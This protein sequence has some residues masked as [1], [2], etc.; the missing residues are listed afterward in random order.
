[1]TFACCMHIL[2]QTLPSQPLLPFSRTSNNIYIV[3]HTYIYIHIP[4]ACFPVS[5]FAS[6]QLVPS[7]L[8]GKGFLAT[9][10]LLICWLCSSQSGI[11]VFYLDASCSLPRPEVVR[12]MTLSFEKQLAASVA[13]AFGLVLSGVVTVLKMTW[14]INGQTTPAWFPTRRLWTCP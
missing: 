11:L 13:M 14:G 8:L 5:G 9:W 12:A 1:M 10:K 4:F 7:A 6:V 3:V 2:I